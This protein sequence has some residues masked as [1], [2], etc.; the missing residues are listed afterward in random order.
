VATNPQNIVVK[1]SLGGSAT[2]AVTLK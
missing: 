2:R 1:S